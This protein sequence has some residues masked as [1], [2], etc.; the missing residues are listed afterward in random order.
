MNPQPAYGK[1]EQVERFLQTHRLGILTLL[2][3]D[4]VGSTRLKQTLGDA[5]GA[6]TCARRKVGEI[7]WRRSPRAG[8]RPI[9]ILTICRKPRD[10]ARGRVLSHGE[11]HSLSISPVVSNASPIGLTLRFSVALSGRTL[12]LQVL[13]ERKKANE[14]PPQ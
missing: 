13:K 8:T 6:D 4:M 1:R 14:R 12:V 3:T 5:I 7:D 10:G 2:F 11:S 9:T